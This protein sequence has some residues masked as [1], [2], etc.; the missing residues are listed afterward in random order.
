ML[1]RAASFFE[2][3]NDEKTHFRV[4]LLAFCA[5]GFHVGVWAVLLADLASSLS[6][7]PGVLGVALTCQSAAGVVALLVG[8]RIAD[9]FGRRPVLVV[10]VAGTGVYFLLLAFVESYPALLAVLIFSGVVSLY[11]LACN[12]LGGDYERQHDAKAMTL[13]HA[14]FSGSGALGA[15]GSGV[16]LSVGVGFGEIYVLTGAAML[17][18]AAASLRMPLPRRISEAEGREVSPRR[19]F[20]LLRVPSVLACAAIIFMCFSTDAALEGYTSIYLRD[21]L[22]AGALLGGFGLASLYFA[23]AVSRL[24]SAAAIL[25]FGERKILIA[26]G[27]VAALGLGLALATN[28]P[29]V[30]AVGLLLV[31]AALAPV[32][33]IISS[34]TAR[35]V[36]DNSGQAM[37]LVITSG[38]FAFTLSPVLV[39]GLADAS[40]LRFAFLLLLALCAGAS[41]LSWRM[42]K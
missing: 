33:P 14:G 2:A 19:A 40:S 6:L 32:A 36:P 13:F 12:S 22:G 5:L 41:L 24:F 10:G 27:V 38:Y 11:D 35:A 17:L 26:S 4:I 39:G 15:L 28:M 9:R 25:R 30:A 31:G 1:K 8:G 18:L 29:S 3:S 7:S 16:A 21:L 42:P 20:A 23:G 37:S 34:I